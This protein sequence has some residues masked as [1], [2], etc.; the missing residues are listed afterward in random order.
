[1]HVEGRA[2]VLLQLEEVDGG[3]AGDAIEVRKSACLHEESSFCFV[4]RGFY[5][6]DDVEASIGE[7]GENVVK[8]V[9]GSR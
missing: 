3:E 2:R 5:L 9:C 6:L 7:G 4:K 8:G 1:L